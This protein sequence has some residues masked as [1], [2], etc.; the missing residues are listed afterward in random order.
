MSDYV[1]RGKRPLTTARPINTPVANDTYDAKDLRPFD[2]R[3]GAMDAYRLPSII[4][5]REVPRGKK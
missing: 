4:N 3:S 1:R 2:G 5:G